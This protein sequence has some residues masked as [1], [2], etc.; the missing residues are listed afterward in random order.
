MSDIITPNLGLELPDV[1][2]DD[3]D[4]GNILN[5]DLQIIDS[6]TAPRIYVDSGL[7]HALMDD[8]DY[9]SGGAGG[10]GGAAPGVSSFNGRDGDVMLSPADV[11]DAG[12]LST[13]GGIVNG[14]LMVMGQAALV[15]ADTTATPTPQQAALGMPLGFALAWGLGD[16]SQR[17]AAFIRSQVSSIVATPPA[18]EFIDTGI[19]VSTSLTLPADPTNPL[20]AATRQYVDSRA[21]TP[22][23]TGPAGPTG[24]TGPAGPG[25]TPSD[26]APLVNGTA[27]PG[28]SALYA[29]GDHVHPTDTSRAPLASPVFT[30]D[31]RAVRLPQLLWLTPSLATQARDHTIGSRS[32]SRMS[33]VSRERRLLSRFGR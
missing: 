11:T 26:A 18:L 3:N 25:S 5:R 6:D 31:A 2:A 28:T 22:G 15:M 23:P 14:S 9:G 4:W 32:R 13:G 20:H 17:V 21:M 7:S 12:G 24:A 30:G 33:G 16:G 19:T 1:G 8:L 10:G 27:A 29:R